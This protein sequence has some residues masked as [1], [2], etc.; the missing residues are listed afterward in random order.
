MLLCNHSYYSFI[1]FLL[2]FLFLSLPS[3]S[4][5]SSLS[6]FHPCI[7]SSIPWIATYWYPPFHF[8]LPKNLF[9]LHNTWSI[10]FSFVKVINQVHLLYYLKP[11]NSFP[12]DWIFSD[13]TNLLFTLLQPHWPPF[14]FQNILNSFWFQCLFSGIVP[15][16]WNTP[17]RPFAELPSSTLLVKC[18]LRA[19][20]TTQSK[21]PTCL[22]FV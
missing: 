22:A 9:S 21:V 14:C 17:L 11:F 18:H 1:H 2:F 3:S 15:S 20:L 7:H 19:S 16:I 5:S 4:F 10:F 8:C 6:S 13:L 12:W